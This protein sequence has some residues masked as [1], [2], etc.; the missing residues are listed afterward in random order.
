[1]ERLRGTESTI[2]SERLPLRV[3]G[4]LRAPGR[5]RLLKLCALH[6]WAS[7]VVA[8]LGGVL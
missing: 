3:V 8:F 1:M 4:C 7:L 2:Y 6:I 5:E